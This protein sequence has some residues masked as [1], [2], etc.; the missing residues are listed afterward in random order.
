M[1]RSQL[2]A[3]LTRRMAVIRSSS[4]RRCAT[5]TRYCSTAFEQHRGTRACAAATKPPRAMQ[6]VETKAPMEVPPHKQEG[7]KGERE[8]VVRA[9]DFLGG[10]AS[11][12]AW[13]LCSAVRH[14]GS[15]STPVLGCKFESHHL[16]THGLAGGADDLCLEGDDVT[17]IPEQKFAIRAKHLVGIKSSG[18]SAREAAFESEV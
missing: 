12:L 13:W 15:L 8:E 10:F 7:E 9:S 17:H 14:H 6:V 11:K 16:V 4:C 18:T 5:S 3:P 1:T 2:V